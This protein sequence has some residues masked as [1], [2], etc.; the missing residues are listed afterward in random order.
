M[1]QREIQLCSANYRK[2]KEIALN[3]KD[4]GEVKRAME[5]A[6]F[7]LELQAAYI[8]LWAVEQVRG[9]EPGFEE[10]LFLAKLN[11]CKKLTEHAKKVIDE[12]KL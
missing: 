8:A 12:L 9:S 11:L 6:F 1:L 7:W 10:K 2:W 3:S 5:K 4:M